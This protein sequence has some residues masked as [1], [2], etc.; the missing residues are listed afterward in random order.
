MRREKPSAPYGN[1]VTVLAWMP[2]AIRLALAQGT[3]LEFGDGGLSEQVFA[4]AE[5]RAGKPLP[6]ALIPGIRLDS[7]KIRRELT[8]EWF[9]NRVD[10]RYQAC[11]RR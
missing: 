6:R 1:W 9:A 2:R 10:G 5:A 8:T 11:M 3:Q 4:L 7:P